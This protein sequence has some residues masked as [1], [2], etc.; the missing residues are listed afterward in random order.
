[1]LDDIYFEADEVADGPLLDDEVEIE[2]KAS[3]I[4]HVDPFIFPYVV[5]H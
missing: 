3:G 2:I 1:M 4:K 5:R